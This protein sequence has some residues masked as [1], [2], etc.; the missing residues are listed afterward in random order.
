VKAISKIL[1]EER[2]VKE[3]ANDEVHNSVS[4]SRAKATGTKTTLC[5]ISRHKMNNENGNYFPQSNGG[6]WRCILRCV[7]V[8][9]ASAVL[10]R[11]T[12]SIRLIPQTSDRQLGNSASFPLIVP[13]P[14]LTEIVLDDTDEYLVIANKKLW[15]VMRI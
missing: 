1:L 10:V 15:A 11:Q 6:G 4:A 8:G 7:S 9:E 3:T 2:T 14:E 5:H 12:G 13:D